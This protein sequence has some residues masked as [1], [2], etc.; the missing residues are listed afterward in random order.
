MGG[1]DDGQSRG[2][3]GDRALPNGCTPKLALLQFVAPLC[4][5]L[6]I[7]TQDPRAVGPA[8]GTLLCTHTMFVLSPTA[9]V[10]SMKAV[11]DTKRAMVDDCSLEV[12]TN[13]GKAVGTIFIHGLFS[14]LP[15]PP[16][17]PRQLFSRT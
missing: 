11:N 1:V 6:G 9:T 16:E 3:I 15:A 17:H 13:D 12:L 14:G 2:G 4:V 8:K 7:G 10:G 5:Q